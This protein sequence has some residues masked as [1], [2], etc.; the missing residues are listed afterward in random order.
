MTATSKHFGT[1]LLAAL[2]L[3]SASGATLA[4][5]AE[6]ERVSVYQY[7]IDHPQADVQMRSAPSLGASVPQNVELA[8]VSGDEIYGYFYYDGR[9][10]LVELKT[11]SV[12]R[13]DN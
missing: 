8:T 5:S 12:V 3:A 2:L 1:A 4:Q 7:A 11:R 6:Q 9:P 13:I 10:V